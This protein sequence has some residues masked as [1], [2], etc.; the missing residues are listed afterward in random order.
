MILDFMY[1]LDGD[2]ESGFSKL[3]N[4]EFCF[5]KLSVLS[6]YVVRIILR[7]VCLMDNCSVSYED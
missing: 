5:L 3:N 4:Y 1:K 7:G 2:W 6:C